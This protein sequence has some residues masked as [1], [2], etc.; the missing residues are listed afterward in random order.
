M[1]GYFTDDVLSFIKH[2]V[3]HAQSKYASYS[4]LMRCAV[5]RLC[6]TLFN[7]VNAALSD[8]SN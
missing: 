8:R 2:K 5:H 6:F 4:S 7:Y 1:L 3:I